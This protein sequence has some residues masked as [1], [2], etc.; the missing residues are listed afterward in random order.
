MQA[1]DQLVAGFASVLS[2]ETIFYCFIGCL[3]G[4]IVGVLPGL[5]PLAGMVLLL[6]LT[7][8][9]D[10]A[11]GIIMLA[12][13]FYGAMY[14][15]STTS[16]LVRIP[17]EAASVITC[18]D[19]YEMARRGRA[20]PAL[21]IAALGS[22]IGGTV[23]V[24]GLMLVAPPLAS[25]MVAIGP[26]VQVVLM[27]LA[28]CVI[29]LVSAGSRSKAAAMIILGLAVGT[30]GLDALTGLPR[31][32][33]GNLGLADGLSF[34]A[35]AIGLFGISEILLNLEKSET[36]K[37]ITPKLRELVPRWSDLK[38]SAPAIGRGTIIGFI[39]GIVPGVSHVVSTFVSY[40][41]EKRLAKH[42]EQFGRGAIAGVA[43]PETANNATTGTA[44]IP[45]LA[46][47]IPSIPATAILLSALTIHGVV[48]GPLLM[49]EH[50]QVFWGL[51]ASMYIGNAV[52]L[53]LNLPF[54]G[55]FVNLLRIPYGWLVP[56]ILVISTIGVYSVSFKA[57]DIWIM[58][59]SGGAG[60]ILRK[61]GYEMAPLLL[62]LVLGDQLEENFRLAL[63]MSGGSYATFADQ[64]ALIVIASVSGLLLILQGVAWVFGYR[65]SLAD[66][67]ERQ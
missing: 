14:G 63:T 59:L 47:G 26:S 56:A 60:Y 1:F 49:S 6:P 64:A 11:S 33:F 41:V 54:V 5:G 17:G 45:L 58:V 30:I 55:L 40:A 8:G 20:G 66:E 21:V 65:K 27:L 28:L 4:T 18:I 67:A 38:E 35:L 37:A 39:F 62:A 46:L 57:A 2:W 36:I 25:V 12:G 22:F 32:T 16:I 9:L 31:F 43:G 52:L 44:M 29:T 53:V 48:P 34:T 13:I 15:G 23:S 50:P 61:F 24:L 7:F 42:P 3:W 19:G 10:P 51:V